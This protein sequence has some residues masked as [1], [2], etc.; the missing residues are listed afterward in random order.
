[1]MLG[2]VI[3]LVENAFAPVNDKL[4]LACT[5]AD[6]VKAH[7]DGFGSFLLDGVV[8]D[9]RGSRV[10][11]GH[12]SGRLLVSEFFEGDSEWACFTTIVE[13]GSKFSFSGT[14]KHFA[15]DVAHDMDGAVVGRSWVSGVWRFGGVLGVA[16]EVVI[17]GCTGASLGGGEIGGITVNMEDHVAG[18][19][20]YHSVGVGGTIIKSL[21]DRLHG[22]G[23]WGGLLGGVP[24]AA[25]M[26]LSTA[27]P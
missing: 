6:P 18:V 2:E 14:G 4:T 8:G 26:V 13:E 16:A 22:F 25:M 17:A 5:V 3:G 21:E 23:S 10:V 11:G 19:E 1:M 9:A 20:A 24:R 15:H 27:R 7:V 12:R